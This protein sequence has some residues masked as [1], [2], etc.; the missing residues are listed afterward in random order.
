[1]IF[2]SAHA[3]HPY[4]WRLFLGEAGRKWAGQ[5]LDLSSV[6]DLNDLAGLLRH[7]ADLSESRSKR[8]VE[9]LF[10]EFEEKMQRAA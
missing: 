2:R 1:M 4:R 7:S 10:Q 3:M 5:G 6:A 8:E 9:T